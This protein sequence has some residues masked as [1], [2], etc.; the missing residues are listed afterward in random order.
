MTRRP[1]TSIVASPVLI[2]AVTILVTIVAVFLAY[3]AN[4]GLP[5]VPN[6][7]VKVL[8]KNAAAAGRGAEVR[9]GGIRVGFVREVRTRALEDGTAA[10]EIH[11]VLEADDDEIP[12]DTT[13]TIRPRSPLGLKYLE[14]ARGTA[15]ETAAQDHVFPVEQ[16]I[17]PVEFDDVAR[18]YD[19][20]TRRG[21][22]RSLQGFGTALAGRGTYLNQGIE[23]LPRLFHHLEP[24]MRTL[25]ARE[26]RLGRFFSELG[27]AARVVAPLADE[28]SDFFTQAGLTFEALSREPESLKATIERTHP[29]LQAGI[30]SFP[31][32][33]PFLSDS[34]AL[35]RE[36]QP[37]A[38]ELRPALPPLN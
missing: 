8:A 26:T 15:T 38:R 3:N 29:A 36:M 32:Q 21:I 24:V 11:A 18:S 7:E 10:A 27:D 5:F 22:Q 4:Q 34:A 28:Q 1:A 30:E 12:V 25:A 16:T 37:V 19:A 35:A 20:P 13:F 17:R 2:G 33:R 23:Q 14:M 31:V 9:E 6:L